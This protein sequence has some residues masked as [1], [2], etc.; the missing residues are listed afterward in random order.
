MGHKD[1]GRARAQ[2][3]PGDRDGTSCAPA[4]TTHVSRHFEAAGLSVALNDPYKGG[5]ITTHHGR[6]ADGIHAIQVELRRDLYMDEDTFTISQPGFDQ[7]RDTIDA[8]VASL[9]TFKL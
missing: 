2:V 4:L 6:P 9:R 5:Y 8:L 1:P 7:L 3:V